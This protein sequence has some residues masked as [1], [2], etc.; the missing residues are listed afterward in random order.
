MPK[1]FSTWLFGLTNSVEDTSGFIKP[2]YDI[3]TLTDMQRRMHIADLLVHPIETE[4][5]VRDWVVVFCVTLSD[6]DKGARKLER[7]CLSYLTHIDVSREYFSTK[8]DTQ[9]KA[10]L[11]NLK[12]KIISGRLR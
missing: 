2:S 1:E 11:N 8:G 7:G 12:D 5:D 6:S 10:W 3:T 9:S 4:K